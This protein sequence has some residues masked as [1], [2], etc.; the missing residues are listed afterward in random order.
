MAAYQATVDKMALCFV[1]YE[2]HHIKRAKKE[3]ADAL[4]RLGSSC[5]AVS[6]DVFLEHP[7]VPSV[8]GVHVVY[9]EVSDTPLQVMVVTPNWMV[10]FL[11]YLV[12]GE[13]PKD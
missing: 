12:K 9:P 7:H 1:G 10:P 5:K 4:S 6:S 8:K 13:L 2:V 11:D 3:A